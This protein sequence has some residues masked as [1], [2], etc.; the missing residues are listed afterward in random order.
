MA[1]RFEHV[2]TAR[3]AAI[4]A[5]VSRAHRALRLPANS[6]FH[7]HGCSNCID[8]PGSSND[9]PRSTPRAAARCGCVSWAR[10]ADLMVVKPIMRP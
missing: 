10:R 9:L 4:V 2:K 1:I 3:N 5:A 6:A 8:T 7:R